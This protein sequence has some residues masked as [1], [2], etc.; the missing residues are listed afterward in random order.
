M[1]NL[2]Q[3]QSFD[4][5][6]NSVR[7]ITDPNQEFWFCGVDVCNILGYGNSRATIQKHCKQGGVS[8]RYTP[9]QSG[10]QEMIFINEP[11]LYRLIIKSRKPEAELF[12]TWVFEEVL[13]Q[14]RKTGKYEVQSQQLA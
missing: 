8:K 14:I 3:F 10:E 4:F 1:S 5:H 7:V 2:I 9:T 6:S 13:P 12:E 11:N